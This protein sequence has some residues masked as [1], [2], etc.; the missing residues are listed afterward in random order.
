MQSKEHKY[1]DRS[2]LQIIRDD[3]TALK[4]NTAILAKNIERKGEALVR[5]SRDQLL[6]SGEHELIKLE[7]H[8]K[9][10]PSQSI[11]LAFAA[12]LF[13]SHLLRPRR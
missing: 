12:G 5:E 1:N 6:T 7:K 11:L 4:D 8:I 2:E 9:A 10:K 3:L 13:A